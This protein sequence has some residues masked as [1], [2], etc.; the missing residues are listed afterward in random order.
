MW[1]A[2]ELEERM[3]EFDEDVRIHVNGCPNSCARFQTADIGLLGGLAPRPDGVRGEV[4]LVHLG[5]GLGE[6][7]GFAR[8][9]RGVRVWADET[10]DYV[11]TLLKRYTHRRGSSPSFNTYVRSLSDE[12]L[13]EFA[14]WDR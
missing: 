10:A 12:Q 6:D 13:A 14:R 5:G 3:P 1:L 9:V 2:H 7:G 4:F 11:E 8:K